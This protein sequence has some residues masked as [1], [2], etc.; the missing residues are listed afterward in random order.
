[1]GNNLP[2]EWLNKYF[3]L[4]DPFSNGKIKEVKEISLKC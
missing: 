4:R 2:W 1:M 3:C